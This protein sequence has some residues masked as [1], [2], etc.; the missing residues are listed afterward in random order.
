MLQIVRPTAI[1]L[2]NKIDSNQLAH[3][4]IHFILVEVMCKNL[5]MTWNNV[6]KMKIAAIFK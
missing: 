1:H 3:A 2:I 6:V 4:K 5:E